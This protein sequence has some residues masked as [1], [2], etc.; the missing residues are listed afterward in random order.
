MWING[1]AGLGR[2]KGI[3]PGR[4]YLLT[5]NVSHGGWLSRNVVIQQQI[6]I[7]RIT[8]DDSNTL[9]EVF[10]GITSVNLTDVEDI[11][12]TFRRYDDV[13]WIIDLTP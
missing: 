3:V 4:T 2:D 6:P 8:A 12:F 11:D 13:D 9:P 1:D 7:A 5:L 10:S